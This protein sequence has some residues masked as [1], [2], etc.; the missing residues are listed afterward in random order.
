MYNSPF[1]TICLIR[2][3]CSYLFPVDDVEGILQF[4]HAEHFSDQQIDIEAMN[5]FIVEQKPP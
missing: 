2:E 4:W 5:N 1:E 3:I